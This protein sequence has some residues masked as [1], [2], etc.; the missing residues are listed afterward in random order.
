MYTYICITYMCVCVYPF[1]SWLIYTFWFLWKS[2]W[3]TK[4]ILLSQ[5]Q[6]S[7]KAHSPAFGTCLIIK[8]I[9]HLNIPQEALKGSAGFSAALSNLRRYRAGRVPEA[10][11]SGPASW[12]KSYNF[13]F[14]ETKGG[15][16]SHQKK[17]PA[18]KYT[19]ILPVKDC[20]QGRDG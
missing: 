15:C 5:I 20:H 2:S 13:I 1:I 10:A 8:C 4:S 14:S 9:C 3:L 16:L 11:V 6:N 19:H 12:G 7:L 18:Q 17:M